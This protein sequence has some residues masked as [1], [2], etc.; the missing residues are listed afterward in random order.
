MPEPAA[1][2]MFA[3]LLTMTVPFAFE[4]NELPFPNP[5]EMPSDPA[6]MVPAA[7]TE[8]NELAAGNMVDVSLSAAIPV[9]DELIAP[10][11]MICIS[12]DPF[13]VAL[14]PTSADDMLDASLKMSMP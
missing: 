6:V 4:R 12:P 14:I 1:A 7:T 11:L 2:V 13:S 3:R 10:I 9:L 8:T 5:A